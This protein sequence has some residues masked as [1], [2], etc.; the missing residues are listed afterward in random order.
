MGPLTI[1]ALFGTIVVVAILGGAW[2][3]RR[4]CHKAVAEVICGCEQIGLLETYRKMNEVRCLTR[5]STHETETIRHRVIDLAYARG[6]DPAVVAHALYHILS[7]GV[8]QD[9]SFAVLELAGA[10]V[11]EDPTQDWIE[12]AGRTMRVLNA[13]RACSTAG[14]IGDNLKA[15]AKKL[16]VR[17]E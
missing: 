2:Q 17:W 14:E 16:G 10:V 8:A 15:T 4:M 11:A 3:I 5:W 9:E 6:V 12:A 7:A 1:G 13:Y